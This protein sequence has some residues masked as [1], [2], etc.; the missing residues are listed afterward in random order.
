M[1]R[2]TSVLG[3]RL[4]SGLHVRSANLKRSFPH[5]EKTGSFDEADSGA[6]YTCAWKLLALATLID[7]GLFLEEMYSRVFFHGLH[8]GFFENYMIVY[9]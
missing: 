6:E 9:S 8:G 2:V 5:L 3:P 1:I 7:K 4:W